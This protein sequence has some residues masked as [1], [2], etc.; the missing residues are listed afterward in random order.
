MFAPHEVQ[1][2]QQWVD[3]NQHMT[4]WAYGLAFADATD[5][6]LEALG[7]DAGYRAAEGGTFYTVETHIRFLREVAQGAALSVTSAVLG[8]DATRLH[9]WHDMRDDQRQVVATQESLLVHVATASQ[10]A[11]PMRAEIVARTR[12]R[13]AT[14]RPDVIGHAIRPVDR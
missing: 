6:V 9:L 10:R 5:H 3:Y 12:A 8:A 13:V 1:V 2:E 4:E 7:F 14:T 11:A